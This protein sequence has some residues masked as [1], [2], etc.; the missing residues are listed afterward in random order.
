[1][2]FPPSV[3]PLW[4]PPFPPTPRLRRV[5]GR[6]AACDL[7]PPLLCGPHQRGKT[8]GGQRTAALWKTAQ[9]RQ[10]VA[11]FSQRRFPRRPTPCT[12]ASLWCRAAGARRRPLHP[13]PSRSALVRGRLANPCATAL[14][15]PGALVGSCTARRASHVPAPSMSASPARAGG[16]SRPGS[17]MMLRCREAPSRYTPQGVVIGTRLPSGRARPRRAL[18]ARARPFTLPPIA[19]TARAG[20]RARAA[21]APGS[22][23]GVEPLRLQPGLE[24]AASETVLDHKRHARIASRNRS[25]HNLRRAAPRCR[26][27]VPPRNSFR[28]I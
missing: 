10:G 18:R 21:P 19:V 28:P 2:R 8:A 16:P 20:R 23:V 14:S 12:V 24:G 22:R 3:F 11:G 4:K 17:P 27:V 5:S 26:R 1:M 6:C 15:G 25:R 7:I 9:N 13:A